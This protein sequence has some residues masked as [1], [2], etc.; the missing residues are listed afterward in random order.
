MIGNIF[1]SASRMIFSKKP[2]LNILLQTRNKM[3]SHKSS[4]KRFIRTGTGLKRK[5]AGRNHG[6]S[7]FSANAIRHLDS[8]IPVSDKAGHKKKL[9]KFLPN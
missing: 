9:M 2:A 5:Q 4:A 8:F 7:K 3:R 1:Q 6:N